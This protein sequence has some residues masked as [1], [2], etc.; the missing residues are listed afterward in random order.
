MKFAQLATESTLDTE[1]AW[2]PYAGAVKV[3]LRR[4]GCRAFDESVQK[5]T[6]DLREE[7]RQQAMTSE[8]LIDVQMHALAE[9]CLIDWEGVTE[10]DSE[11][12]MVYTSELGFQAMK[13]NYRFYRDIV[14]LCSDLQEKDEKLEADAV[15]N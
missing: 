15:E 1:G 2:R 10:D 13:D 8:Q 14:R 4:I 9:A 5:H 12:P 6:L 3:K 7:V 11:A